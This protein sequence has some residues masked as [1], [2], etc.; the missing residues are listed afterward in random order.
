MNPIIAKF[1][2]TSMGT[3]DSIGKVADIIATIHAPRAVVVSAVSGVT[4]ELIRL[5]GQAVDG[6]G[7]EETLA[8]IIEKHE[9]VVREL[10]MKLDLNPLYETLANI[11]KG[12][13]LL[14]ELSASA[15]DRIIGFG[16]HISSRILAALLNARKMKAHQENAQEFIF[17]DNNFGEAN[18]DFEKTNPAVVARLKPLLLKNCTPVV[19]GFVARAENGRYSVLGRGGSD[20][21][22]AILA[23][24]LGARELQ[25]WTDVDGIYNADPRIIPEARALEQLSF[26]EA[27]EL[28]YF[29]AKVLHPKTIKPAV[30]KNIPVR[31]LNTFNPDSAGTVITNRER[32]S[33]KSITFKKGITIINVCSAGMLD[34][35]GFLAR[36]FEIFAKH[37]VAVDVVA[38]SEVNVSMTVD[39]G[40]PQNLIKDLEMFSTVTVLRN[41]AIM[42]VIGAG[43]RADTAV[44][45]RLFTAIA[46]HDVN[47]VS[48]GSSKNNITFLVAE[49]E[50][51]EITQKIFKTFFQIYEH[52]NNR[53]NRRSRA[54][55]ARVPASAKISG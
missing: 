16:E 37:N 55:N 1:G 20:Y 6:G 45:G 8:D 21:T 31:I 53:R 26:A 47:M 27:S 32:E 5:C 35:R 54:G 33:L 41:R 13:N 40:V 24:A 42:C 17:T 25:I 3:A 29:G 19:T 9:T 46:D 2:G 12:V 34:A 18:V 30:A 48:Q 28:A 39:S 36:L 7:W 51:K 10:N 49:E 23:S 52:S 38:T 43:I 14:G 4:D 50:A 22:A 44:L 15:K 11:I